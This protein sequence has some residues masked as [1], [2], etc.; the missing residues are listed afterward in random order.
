LKYT[1][2][3]LYK[4]QGEL[5]CEG[6]RTMG[7]LQVTFIDKVTGKA[8]LAC[9]CKSEQRVELAIPKEKVEPKKK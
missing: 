5:V 1:I 8:T 4:K 7:G 3:E 2:E 6:C 9:R